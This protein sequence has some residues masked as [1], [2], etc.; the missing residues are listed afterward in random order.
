MFGPFLIRYESIKKKPK[1]VDTLAGIPQ[2][3]VMVMTTWCAVPTVA[4]F[5]SACTSQKH[6]NESL[7]PL[8]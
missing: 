8:D 5:P 6:L 2:T 1:M 3:H 7:Y 4:H